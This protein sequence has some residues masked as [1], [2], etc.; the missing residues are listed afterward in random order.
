M[1]VKEVARDVLTSASMT[2][3]H[4]VLNKKLGL[5]RLVFETDCNYAPSIGPQLMERL[6]KCRLDC[7]EQ[8]LKTAAGAIQGV[9]N[10]SNDRTVFQ[11]FAIVSND[12]V[13]A[14]KPIWLSM[15]TSH[16]LADSKYVVEAVEELLMSVPNIASMLKPAQRVLT[17]S[18]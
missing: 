2:S 8:V 4:E 17:A 10:H 11:L 18:R 1:G 12:C 3:G 9:K 7:T 5:H 6:K 15:L 13:V 14:M 16:S